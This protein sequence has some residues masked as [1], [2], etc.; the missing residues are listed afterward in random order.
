MWSGRWQTWCGNP[1]GVF[2]SI[3]LALSVHGSCVIL[4]SR[5][6]AEPSGMARVLR[7]KELLSDKIRPMFYCL[8]HYRKV[9]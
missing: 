7:L 8:L 1:L 3:L 6:C 9:G 2:L 5:L 4:P